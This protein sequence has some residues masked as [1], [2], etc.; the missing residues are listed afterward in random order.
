MR[1]LAL[2]GPRRLAR[3]GGLSQ[4]VAGRSAEPGRLKQ[5]SISAPAR[6]PRTFQPGLSATP[7]IAC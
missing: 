3:N 4:S 5:A 6:C 2:G 1:V 7:G